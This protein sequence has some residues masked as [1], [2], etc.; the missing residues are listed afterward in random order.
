VRV[1]QQRTVSVALLTLLGASCEAEPSAVLCRGGYSLEQDGHCYPPPDE[2]DLA[3]ALDELPTCPSQQGDGTIDLLAGCQEVACPG[4]TY[5]EISDSVH[6]WPDCT[7]ASWDDERVYCTWQE[8]GIEGLFADSDED[9]VPDP[10]AGNE[11]VRLLPPNE[12][13]TD[14]GLGV[15]TPPSCWVDALGPPDWIGIDDVAG[16]LEIQEMFWERYGVN[17]YDWGTDDD[18]GKANGLIDNVYLYGPPEE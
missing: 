9:T 13:R 16:T 2:V 5:D 15:G 7:T 6:D 11:R 18:S 17:V 8:A 4:T 3:L 1:T 10:D 12:A 14:D